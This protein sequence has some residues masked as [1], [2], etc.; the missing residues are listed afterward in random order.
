[1]GVKRGTRGYEFVK[2][3]LPRK[4]Q[5]LERR[6]QI[7]FN[8]WWMTDSIQASYSS[9]FPPLTTTRQFYDSSRSPVGFLKRTREGVAPYERKPETPIT[10]YI[11]SQP[12]LSTFHSSSHTLPHFL[13]PAPKPHISYSPYY[14]RTHLKS[15]P[16]APPSPPQPAHEKSDASTPGYQTSSVQTSLESVAY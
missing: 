15:P 6:H 7:A 2:T 14:T 3:L 4:P 8:Q 12:S 13:I 5:G 1:M 16:H 9:L 11:A 10:I